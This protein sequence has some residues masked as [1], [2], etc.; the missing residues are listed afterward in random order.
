MHHYCK[1]KIYNFYIVSIFNKI[2]NGF[3]SDF[4]VSILTLKNIFATVPDKSAAHELERMWATQTHMPHSVGPNIMRH[5]Q[6]FC[7]SFSLKCRTLICITNL[8]LIDLFH[9]HT[10]R[11]PN[12]SHWSRIRIITF[13]CLNKILNI[14][15]K[16]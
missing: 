14:P 4:M 5:F 8:R 10:N 3:S 13:D 11:I 7:V 9:R 2:R 6:K 16:F 15:R 12:G 1:N